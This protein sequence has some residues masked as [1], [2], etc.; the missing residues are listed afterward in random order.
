[1]DIQ[2]WGANT[3]QTVKN[4]NVGKKVEKDATSLSD[5]KLLQKINS[6]S[7]QILNRH[8]HILFPA[9]M[10]A[11]SLPRINPLG[12]IDSIH[13]HPICTPLYQ[14]IDNEGVDKQKVEVS[15]FQYA[16][17]ISRQC[18]AGGKICNFFMYVIHRTSQ[19]NSPM[20]YVIVRLNF[21]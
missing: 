5:P 7:F 3:I 18:G 21:L 13:V 19:K 2:Q 15:I 4:S 6:Y 8:C 9:E 16:S 12:T 20:M 17:Q 11:L 14:L 10:S 1:M